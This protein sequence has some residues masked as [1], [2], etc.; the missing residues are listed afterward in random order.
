MKLKTIHHIVI[1]F[2][3]AG[4]SRHHN[5]KTKDCDFRFIPKS[6]VDWQL[7]HPGSF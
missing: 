6:K 2:P 7:L 4:R 5:F 3:L 1:S